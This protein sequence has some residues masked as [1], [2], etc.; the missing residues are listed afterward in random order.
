MTE[1]IRN[2]GKQEENLPG[3]PSINSFPAFLIRI[4]RTDPLSSR[5]NGNVVTRREF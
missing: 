4:L 1:L 2:A 3:R 5:F